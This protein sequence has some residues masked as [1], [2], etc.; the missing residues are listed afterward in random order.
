MG[1]TGESLAQANRHQTDYQITL[2]KI[3]IQMLQFEIANDANDAQRNRQ[4]AD[5]VANRQQRAAGKQQQHQAH[6]A[7][8]NGGDDPVF[9]YLVP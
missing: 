7:C 1:L 2:E 5:A 9:L 6:D 4:A 3:R 8:H